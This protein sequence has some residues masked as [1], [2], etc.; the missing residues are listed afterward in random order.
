MS[1]R[2]TRG[3]EV[4][5]TLFG[6]APAP[7]REVDAAP[8]FRAAILAGIDE[9]GLGPMLGPLSIGLSAFRVPRADCDLWTELAAAVT[10]ELERGPERFVV[11]DS[12]VVFTRTPSGAARLESTVLAFEA[13]AATRP[14]VCAG[15]RAFLEATPIALRALALEDEAWYAHLPDRLSLEC[16]GAE[17]DAR[18]ALLARTASE[19]RIELIAFAVRAV[20]PADLN[21]SF[22]ETSSK[23]ATHWEACRP[24]MRHLWDEFGCDG[25]DLVVDRH[26]GRMRYAALLR[27]SF[28]EA[29]VA[30]VRELPALSEY[31]LR[32]NE[33]SLR[34]RF[35]EKA[36]SLS[37]SVALAS[38]AAKYAREACMEG[39][40]AYFGG[41]Q[42]GLTPTAGYVTDARR[43]L[44]DAG[45][46]IERSGLAR[47]ALV[48]SR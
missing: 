31:V 43:W 8:P 11:A 6:D 22:A 5:P 35:C 32:A 46:A 29:D 20:P 33:R 38:C 26:G 45:P 25:V 28:P 2:R 9:A 1:A 21:A 12:K 7:L 14:T 47:E 39:F 42:Q 36:E 40:N 44:A 27:E 24:F 3:R 23:G 37:F 13:L 17:F 34:V 15:T 48:R 4:G 19:A 16:G 30:I 41:L 10:R 18:V